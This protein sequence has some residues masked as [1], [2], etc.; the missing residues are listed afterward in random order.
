MSS[1]FL[2]HANKVS[3]I[4]ETLGQTFAAYESFS[5]NYMFYIMTLD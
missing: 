5:H 1:S 4:S 2:H 3:S